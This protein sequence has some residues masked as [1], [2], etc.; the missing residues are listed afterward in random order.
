MRK[1]FA[2]AIGTFMLVAVICGATMISFD[3]MGGGS[4]IL[5]VALAAGLA[6]TAMVYAVGPVSG[7]HFN[8]AVT[9]GLFV[10]GRFPIRSIAPYVLAHVIGGALAALMFYIILSSKVGWWPGGFA[11]NGFGEHSPGSYSASAG[12][13]A[14]AV[15]T[16]LFVFVFCR[17]TRDKGGAAI[18]APLAI[19]LTFAALYIASLP[20]TGASLNPAR[21]TATALFAEAWAVQQLWMFWLAPLLGG[22]AGGIADRTVGDVS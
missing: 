4:G 18:M 10:A 14:E 12:F 15:L 5:G 7:G 16:A 6:V 17:V 13:A 8:P 21:S 19:G 20:I 2:E 3:A 1:L 22:V 9:C 11:A